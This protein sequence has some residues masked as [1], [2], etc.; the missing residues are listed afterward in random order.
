MKNNTLKVLAVTLL[1]S[2]ALVGCGGGSDDLVVL[3][4]KPPAATPVP[5]PAPTAAPT[6]APTP[7]PTTTPPTQVPDDEL[8]P[9]FK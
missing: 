7:A 3:P 4:A 1:T 5:T 9:S 2:F 8:L 6:P